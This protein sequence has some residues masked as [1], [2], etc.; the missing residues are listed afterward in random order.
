MDILNGKIPTR[1]GFLF[2]SND[3]SA[4]CMMESHKI[5]PNRIIFE[6]QN[7]SSSVNF[8]FP[9]EEKP[10]SVKERNENEVKETAS[11]IVASVFPSSNASD[12]LIRRL[13]IEY[14]LL[15][16]TE[17]KKSLHTEIDK[18]RY[19]NAREVEREYAPRL[20]VEIYGFNDVRVLNGKPVDIEAWKDGVRY[21][22]DVKYYKKFPSILEGS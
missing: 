10:V 1:V 3:Q 2:V 5:H 15:K 21:H 18:I 7:E 9:E 12:D 13:S 17:E 14:T 11:Q 19:H 22:I 8:V 20:L 4:L 6:N 16:I